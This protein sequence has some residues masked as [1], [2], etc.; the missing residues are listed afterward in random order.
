MRSWENLEADV[1][2]IMNK[3]FT[4]GRGGHSIEAIVLHHNAGNL[5]VEGCYQTWQTRQCSEHYQVESSGRIGQL[6][7]D[8]DTAWNCGDWVWNQKTIGIEHANNSFGPWTIGEATLDNGA[9]LVAALCHAYN[10]GSPR[11]MVNVFPHHH[12]ASTACPGEIAGSQNKA[13]MERAKYWYE[14]MGGQSQQAEPSSNANASG[15]DVDALARA[16]LRGEYGNGAERK[17]RLGDKYQAVQD[18]VNELLYG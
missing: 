12:F 15:G 14:V 4:S 1:N 13:Y 17:N 9:H 2:M 7:W 5:T 10:L 16:V 8:K 11:W 6:V 18:R 3:H